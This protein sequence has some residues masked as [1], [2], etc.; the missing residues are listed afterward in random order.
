M[1]GTDEKR[2]ADLAK[3]HIA[4]KDLGL[5]DDDYRAV[6]QSVDPRV[7]SAGDLDQAGRASL[8]VQFRKLGWKAKPG[9]QP[10]TGTT[11]QPAKIRAL[12]LELH[13]VGAV[14]DPSE[15]ALSAFCKRMTKV[16]RPEWLGADDSNKVIEAL[17]DWLARV[18][19]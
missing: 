3:I 5:S 15:K 12:W 9:K 2:R 4:R 10:R 18:A 14:Q 6:L 8:L 1:R 13:R 17:K 7:E 16:D 11:G 19:Q